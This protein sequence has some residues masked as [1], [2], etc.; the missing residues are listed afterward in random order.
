MYKRL[1]KKDICRIEQSLPTYQHYYDYI[2]YNKV[3]NNFQK[4]ENFRP[5]KKI[6][7]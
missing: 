4:N 5:N 6:H 1:D 3:D 2:N 7:T